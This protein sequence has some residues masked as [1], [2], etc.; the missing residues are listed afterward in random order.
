M[1]PSGKAKQIIIPKR[2]A[3]AKASPTIETKES[4]YFNPL[5]KPQKLRTPLGYFQSI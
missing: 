4:K 3:K 2:T 1:R 5:S